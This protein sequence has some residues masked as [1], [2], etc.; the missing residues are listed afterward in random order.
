MRKCGPYFLLLAL[1]VTA[2]ADQ[3]SFFHPEHAELGGHGGPVARF[4]TMNYRDVFM[5][6]GVFGISTNPGF[7]WIASVNYLEADADQVRFG[8]GS[9]GTETSFRYRKR[10]QPMGQFQLGY[11]LVRKDG[12]S[13]GAVVGE[14]MGLI[15]IRI[16]YGEKII[17]GIGYR[18]VEGIQGIPGIDGSTL[19][20]WQTT[21]RLDFG[22]YDAAA[23]PSPAPTRDAP[24]FSG[25]YSGKWTSIAGHPAWLDG[26]G[27]AAIFDRH[28]SLGVSGYHSRR[29]AGDGERSVSLGYGGLLGRY[30]IAPMDRI[31]AMASILSGFGEAGTAPSEDKR[32]ATR[33]TPVFDADALA[34][35]N[36]TGF[37]RIGIGAGYRWVPAHIGGLGPQAWGG[38]TATLQWSTAAF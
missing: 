34:E 27:A 26:G 20:G 13:S 16:G 22:L 8:Y 11:G 38:P 24:V 19:D 12:A 6:G 10:I 36:L 29:N 32:K 4:T 30:T 37:L 5:G 7:S 33:A 31:H 3:E 23:H 1:A 25:F 14:L 21:M 35:F 15:G 2:F 9:L 18:E 28:W 17:G